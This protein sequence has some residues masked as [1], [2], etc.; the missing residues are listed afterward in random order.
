[1]SKGGILY[2]QLYCKN[3]SPSKGECC[4]AHRRDF[5]GLWIAPWSDTALHWPHHHVVSE[6]S[7]SMVK[8]CERVFV[9]AW[10]VWC[11][12]ERDL[13]L[14][15]VVDLKKNTFSIDTVL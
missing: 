13:L 9:L 5:A 8:Y 15:V 3:S 7:G 2:E 14:I 1:M 12:K 4:K 11:C 6:L 10:L